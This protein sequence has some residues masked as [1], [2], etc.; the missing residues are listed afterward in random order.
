MRALCLGQY[1]VHG[2]GKYLFFG[3]IE[4]ACTHVHTHVHSHTHKHTVAFYLLEPWF[5]EM[6]LYCEVSE[7]LYWH[8]LYVMNEDVRLHSCFHRLG[9]LV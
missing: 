3:F 2:G 5:P 6:R 9:L 4:G 8:Y 1:L 7:T